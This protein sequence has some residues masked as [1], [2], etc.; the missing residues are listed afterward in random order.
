MMHPTA[1][2]H[3]DRH[4]RPTV[5]P[6][7]NHRFL[8]QVISHFGDSPPPALGILWPEL[9]MRRLDAAFTTVPLHRHI[10]EI[11]FPVA[12]FLLGLG[13]PLLGTRLGIVGP[14]LS[15]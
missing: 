15:P 5:A 3:Q 1:G 4:H 7:K 14:I 11:V 12:G 6:R 9:L 10:T 13:V 2:R 8:L